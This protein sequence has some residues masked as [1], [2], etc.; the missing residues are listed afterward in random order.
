M[1]SILI[2][3]ILTAGHLALADEGGSVANTTSK[4][5]FVPASSKFHWL[6]HT[7]TV[8][9]NEEIETTPGS[10][11]LDVDD[12]AT[13]GCGKWE[14]N[15][16]FDG[17]LTRE[18]KTWELPLLDVNYGIGD[19]LQLKYEVPNVIQDSPDSHTASIGDTKLGLKFQFYGDDE[20]KLQMAVYP[21]VQFSFLKK[22]PSPEEQATQGAITTLPILI[23]KRIARFSRGDLMLSANLGYNISTKSDVSDFVSA[24][25][26]V[27]APLFMKTSILAELVTTQAF[28]PIGEDPVDRLLKADVGIMGPV[29]KSIVLYASVGKSLYTSDQRDHTYFVGGFRILTGE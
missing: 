17:D 15:V 13:P 6:T 21:Q 26:G 4:R 25:V 24:A 20:S 11:P 8:E 1:K 10:P 3:L 12:P 16:T 18:E 7:C 14:I 23:A 2:A 19:N 28:R 29:T 9:E 22:N 27:G 5:E